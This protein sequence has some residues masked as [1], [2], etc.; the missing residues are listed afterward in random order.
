[1]ARVKSNKVV[2]SLIASSL[3]RDGTGS[4]S[5]EQTKARYGEVCLADLQEKIDN[6]AKRF[7][8]EYEQNVALFAPG[9]ESYTQQVAKW[10][11]LAA[12]YVVKTL[13]RYNTAA[14]MTKPTCI[15][16]SVHAMLNDAKIGPNDIDEANEMVEAW[17]DDNNGRIVSFGRGRNNGVK[18]LVSDAISPTPDEIVETSPSAEAPF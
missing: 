15:Q 17:L 3:V 14:N 16:L 12:E 2:H 7:Q 4:P 8:E 6:A 18:S 11:P 9:F 13:T 1:M 5:F 10:A